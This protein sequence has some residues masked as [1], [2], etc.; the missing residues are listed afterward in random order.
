MVGV[1]RVV[2]GEGDGG[3]GRE[4]GGRRGRVVGGEGV[5]PACAES[6]FPFLTSTLSCM[7]S[8]KGNRRETPFVNTKRH[9]Y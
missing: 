8:S 1:G 6:F 5:S 2:G 9:T 4:S 7:Y 3:K